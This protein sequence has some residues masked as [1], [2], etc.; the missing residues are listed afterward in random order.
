[1]KTC[2][3]IGH[4]NAPIALQE[5]LNRSVEKMVLEYGIT[6]FV[7]GSH[8]NFDHMAIAA[9]QKMKLLHPERK[10]Y[11]LIA[12]HPFDRVP[13]LPEHFDSTFYPYSLETSPKRFAIKKANQL[14]LMQSDCLI[15]YV[16]RSGGNSAEILKKARRLELEGQL[17]VF[18][19]GNDLLF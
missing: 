2:F 4:R 17:R 3:F 7:V 13:F 18:N 5:E 16:N 6:D 1:M 8:G 19:L 12:N 15:A 9:I 14:M 10:A 11:L